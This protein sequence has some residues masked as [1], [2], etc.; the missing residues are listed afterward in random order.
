MRCRNHPDREAAAICQKLG[1]GFCA[2][3]CDCLNLEQ[4]CACL[5]PQVYC[6]FRTQCLIWEHTRAQR[7][8]TKGEK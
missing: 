6:T 5:D 3:C 4:C 8:K 1:T 2:E 7:R